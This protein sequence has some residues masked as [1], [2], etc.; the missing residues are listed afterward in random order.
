[1]NAPP[2]AVPI[3]VPSQLLE[4]RPDIAA[5]ERAMAAA[6]AQIGIAK[7]AFYP[8]LTLSATGGFQSSTLG[9]LF[10]WSSRFW[11]VGSSVSQPVYDAGLRRAAENQYIEVYNSDV[12]GYRQ[13]VL[14]AFQ[15]VEDYLAAVRILSQQIQQQQQAEQSAQKFVD[16]ETARYETGVDPYINV[17][18]AQTTLLNDQQTLAS[19]H[20]QEMTAS[21][22]LIEALGGG[23]D[24][25]Q[26][27]T[28]A[29]VSVKMTPAETTI[30]K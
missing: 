24:S 27:P 4:R 21:V 14:A 8:A 19:L 15:Q 10:D 20:T 17:V 18:T 26:L 16:L 1:L 5:S 12:A 6:N 30:Q 9:R 11:S 28:P 2:P 23:W 7:A 22:Q 29:Q 25:S 3:G 13:T